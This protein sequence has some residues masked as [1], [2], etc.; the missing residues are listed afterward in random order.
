MK[1][2]IGT[3]SICGGAVTVPSVWMGIIAP[4]PTCERCGAV[5]ASHGPTIPMRRDTQVTG[6]VGDLA[7]AL[8]R[9]GAPE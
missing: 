4:E 6:T 7:K 8:R 2:T 1:T 3:C 5:A 9:D